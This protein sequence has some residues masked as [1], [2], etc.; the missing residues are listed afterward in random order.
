MRLA[1][2]HVRWFQAILIA[3]LDTHVCGRARKTLAS[4]QKIFYSNW[5]NM[6]AKKLLTVHLCKI[7]L[8]A[9]LKTHSVL[10]FCAVIQSWTCVIGW[11]LKD[12]RKSCPVLSSLSCP[13]FQRLRQVLSCGVQLSVGGSGNERYSVNL[14]LLSIQNW[15]GQTCQIFEC[16]LSYV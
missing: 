16:V 3:K 11:V 5:L 10:V 13:P 14:I 8:A 15:P 12:W 4:L 9:L 1:Y 6:W 2:K 7:T